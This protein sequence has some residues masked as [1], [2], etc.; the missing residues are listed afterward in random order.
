M[1]EA[2][3]QSLYRG[4]IPVP[5]R[6]RR[7]KVDILREVMERYDLTA[8]QLRG[9]TRCRAV[10]HPRQEAMWLMFQE[11]YGDSNIAHFL[12]RTSWTVTHG[13]EAHQKRLDERP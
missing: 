12:N 11:G 4:L 5:P 6:E 10:A 8:A 7:A 1:Q 13:R 9:D 2:F 3:Y